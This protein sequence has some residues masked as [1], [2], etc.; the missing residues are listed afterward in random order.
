[1]TRTL[2]GY[3]LKNDDGTGDL[4]LCVCLRCFEAECHAM[5]ESDIL[6]RVDA[7]AE[8]LECDLCQLTLRE[9]YKRLTE[10]ARADALGIL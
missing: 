2:F 8:V 1:M 3:V 10:R 4:S 6:L 9:S 5:R 7:R